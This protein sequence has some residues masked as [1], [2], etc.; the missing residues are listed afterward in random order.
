MFGPYCTQILADLGADVIKIEPLEGD[1]ARTSVR[2]RTR[3][4]W[5]PSICASIEESG[6]S[7]GI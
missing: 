1:T 2:P 4:A 6:P 3:L 5:A 7:F